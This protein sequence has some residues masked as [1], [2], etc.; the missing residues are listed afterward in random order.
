MTTDNT[1]SQITADEIAL[2][3]RQIR[4]WGVKAQE[5]LRTA[6]ILLITLRSLGAEVAKNLVLVGIGS[7]TIIDNATVREE[8]VGAQF[9]LSEEHISQN[10]AEAA[11]PQIRQMNPR[12]QVTV[13]AVNI[14]SKPPAFFAS[15][16]VTIATDLD[17]DTLCWINNSCRVANR[18][19]YAAGIH[20]FYGYIFSDQL[21]HDFVI[22]R[23]KSNVASSTIETPTRTILDV[24]TKKENDK[25]IEMITK[26]EVYCPLMLSNTSSLPQ[27]FTKVRR[28]RLQVT[29]LLTCLRALWEF[30]R[31]MNGSLPTRDDLETF[32]RLANDR[33]LEL[34]LDISTLTAEFIRSFLDNLG[35]ELSPVAAFLGGAAAQDV[36]NVLGAREQPLQNLLLFDGER[37]VAPIYS[38]HPIFPEE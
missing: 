18:R 7:L 12:V 28:K 27:E 1:G 17:Y 13:E 9:F 33:H 37:S 20:G 29:P 3:D 4:L 6:K 30:Q 5:K 16:D 15:Y 10:R 31:E 21:S 38:L 36:I 8:D 11:A 19:F 34:R 26:R 25:V 35:S 32:L 14:R 2:Y 23:E 22:E 24:K